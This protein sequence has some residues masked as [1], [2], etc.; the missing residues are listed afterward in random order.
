VDGS[1]IPDSNAGDAARSQFTAVSGTD[2]NIGSFGTGSW[3]NYTHLYPAGTYNVVG[4]FAE[5]AGVAGANLALITANGT[6]LLGTFTIQNMGW[7]TWQWQ[8]LLDG[9]GNPVKVALDGTAQTLRLGGTT[10]NEVNVNFLML[11]ATTPA[12]PLTAHVAGGLITIS[13]ATQ[14]GYSYQ[15]QY[16]NNLT[17][18]TWTSIGGVI[19][20]DNT[21]HP[22]SDSSTGS[23]RFYQVQIQ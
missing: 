18:A 22:A 15:L 21:V 6:N 1:N 7:G 2:Y 5:G 9:S 12:P 13:F 11:L 19:T 14:T 10:G 20:G 8:E 4:R 3:A 16:K 17:D 23:H